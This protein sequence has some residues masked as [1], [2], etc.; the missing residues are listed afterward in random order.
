MKTATA[1][2]TMKLWVLMLVLVLVPNAPFWEYFEWLKSSQRHNEELEVHLD[3]SSVAAESNAQ[4]SQIYRRRGGARRNN[5]DDDGVGLS[6]KKLK[7]EI[8]ADAITVVS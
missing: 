6:A 2:L 5:D 7:K 8:V 1:T 3:I 4:P